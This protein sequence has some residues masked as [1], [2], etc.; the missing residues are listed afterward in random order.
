MEE[1]S[2]QRN[3]AGLILE[4]SVLKACKRGQNYPGGLSSFLPKKAKELKSFHVGMSH[5]SGDRKASFEG[6]D[7]LL[8][9]ACQSPNYFLAQFFRSRQSVTCMVRTTPRN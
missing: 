1:D 5:N 7:R 6:P 3:I 9:T 2:N 4:D 8:R